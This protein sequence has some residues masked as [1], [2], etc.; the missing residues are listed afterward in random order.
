MRPH[1]TVRSDVKGRIV[2]R[3]ELLC[4][5]ASNENSIRNEGKSIEQTTLFRVPWV[6]LQ[7]PDADKLFVGNVQDTSL[8]SGTT[9][10]ARI[11]GPLT[12]EICR[13]RS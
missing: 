11:V 9:N 4:G 7:M 8:R 5:T 10:A 6:T 3:T 2:P 12:P 13:S 1:S